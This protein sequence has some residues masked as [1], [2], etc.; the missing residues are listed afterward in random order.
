MRDALLGTLHLSIA[1]WNIEH[2]VRCGRVSVLTPVNLRPDGWR[3][4]VVGNFSLLARVATTPEQRSVAKVV[5]AVAGQTR[6]LGEEKSLAMLVEL[7]GRTASLPNWAKRALPA[8]LA[9]TGN[10]LVDTAALSYIDAV[11]EP[12]SFGPNGGEAVELWF[13]PPARMPLGLSIGAVLA[14]RR[15]H[16]AFRYRHALFG[17][18]AACRF[19]DHFVS[20]LAHLLHAP[21]YSKPPPTDHARASGTTSGPGTEPRASRARRATGMAPPA[22]RRDPSGLD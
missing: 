20:L 7:V 13:S 22:R 5:P 8:L 9:I 16:L 6:Q 19:A 1:L 4:E 11:E 21:G 12:L 2:G 10:R 15:L 14:A 17:E 3:E 18:E